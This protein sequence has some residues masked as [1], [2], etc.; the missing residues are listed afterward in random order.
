MELSE[1]CIPFHTLPRMSAKVWFGLL[2]QIILR[3]RHR[4]CPRPRMMKV[5]LLKLQ[6]STIQNLK[7][8][9]YILYILVF[10]AI[11]IF[12]YVLLLFGFAGG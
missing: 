5:G 8:L 4:G 10:M 3:T 9:V 2:I 11:L 6:H 12:Y 7:Y 1:K